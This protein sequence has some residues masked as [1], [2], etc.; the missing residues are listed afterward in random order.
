MWKLTLGYGSHATHRN[1]WFSFCNGFSICV[2]N[3]QSIWDK[4][5]CYWEHVE[6]HIDNFKNMLRIQLEPDGNTLATNF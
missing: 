2:K 5:R 1:T 4:V 3:K 6:E